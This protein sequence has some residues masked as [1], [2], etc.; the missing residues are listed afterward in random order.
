MN[1]LDLFDSYFLMLILIQG[2]IVVFFDAPAFKKRD[3]DRTG[4][5]AKTIGIAIMIIS[6]ALYIARQFK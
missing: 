4:R 1:I 3:L 2:I 6:L 5:K